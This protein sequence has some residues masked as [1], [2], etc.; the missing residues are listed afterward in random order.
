V[1]RAT[2]IHAHAPPLARFQSSRR[3]RPQQRQLLRQPP[4]PIGVELPEQL[5]QERLVR[6]SADEVPAAPQQQRLLQGPLELTMALLH[7]TVL[8]G[9]R[10]LDRLPLQAIMPQQ[11]LVAVGER[12]PPGP[13]RHGGRQTVGT[14]QQRHGPQFPQGIL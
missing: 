13:R 1:D 6:R 12:G 7:V 9:L 4:L 10:R 8:V 11:G 2:A 3:Q 14:V 5:S